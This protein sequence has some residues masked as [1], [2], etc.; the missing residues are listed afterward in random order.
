MRV[1]KGS[2]Q[3]QLDGRIVEQFALS[4]LSVDHL[5]LMR[6]ELVPPNADRRIPVPVAAARIPY[7][8]V[9]GKKTPFARLRTLEDWTPPGESKLRRYAQPRNSGNHVYLPPL[10]DRPWREIAADSSID[11]I[12]T[13]GEKKAASGCAHGFPTLGLGG[14]WNWKS[15]TGPIKDLDLIDWDTRT[16]FLAFDSP[17]VQRNRNVSKALDALAEELR[18]RGAIVRFVHF[19]CGGEKV[20]L[21]DF[22]VAHGAEAMPELLEHATDVPQD[23]VSELNAEL[24]VVAIGAKAMIL[25]ESV[26]REGQT[27]V[28]FARPPDVAP[29][30]LNRTV[31]V[32]TARTVKQ[33]PAFDIWLRSSR[34]RQFKAVVFEPAGTSP[35][36]YNLW[37]GFAVEPIPGDC[38]LFIDHVR[39]NICSGDAGLFAYV[40]G[41]MAHA[42]QKPQELPGT[43]LVLRGKQGVGKSVFCRWFGS[44]FGSHFVQVTQQSHLLGNFNSHLQHAFCVSAEEAVWAGDKAAEG[45]LKAMITEPTRLIEGK[46]KDPITV[47]NFTRLLVSSNHDWP[48]PAGMEERRMVVIDVGQGKMQDV[49][50]FAALGNQ[51]EGGGLSA[52]L[53]VLL[54]RDITE[55]D[56]RRIPKTGALLDTKLRT[57]PPRVR[58]WHELLQAGYNNRDTGTWEP[59]VMCQQLHALY[60]EVAQ[61]SGERRR[62][63]ET[64]LGRTLHDLVPGLSEV[65]R[66]ERAGGP[67]V[68]KWRFPSLEECRR[69]FEAKI[70]QHVEWLSV[71]VE[72]GETAKRRKKP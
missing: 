19:P 67:Q 55:F 60:S 68:R 14:V 44:L 20:G 48:V 33:V 7:F 16:V 10:T 28:D 61:H 17:D 27:V 38:T 8:D 53:D 35:D 1:L 15:D 63:L 21:D 3:V 43:A 65:R 42:V 9:N 32:R 4:G 66:R 26:G 37:R 31:T 57:A 51:M 69:A 22:L 11:L 46:G 72:G 39:D 50:Y 41:W 2:N 52:F 49:G 70:G 30:Y 29:L 25:R 34:R 40:M 59:E 47:R 71:A 13:E 24:A 6:I 36:N 64:E 45:V 12:V 18:G 58:F 54:K 23:A 56:T 5:R 62:A